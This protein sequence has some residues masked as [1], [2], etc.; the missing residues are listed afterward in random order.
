M[1][2]IPSSDDGRAPK[3]RPLA[4]GTGS[5]RRSRPKV[6]RRRA[7]VRGFAAV[8]VLA[9]LLAG[10]WM[11]LRDS[12]LARVTQVYVTGATTSEASSVRSALD[13]AGRE[14]TTL[15]IRRS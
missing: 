13:R 3:F 14:M 2:S 12:S 15:H 10:A 6:T 7:F 1:S 11:W 9:A 4:E 8:V 5:A